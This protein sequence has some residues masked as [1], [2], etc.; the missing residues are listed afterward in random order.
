MSELIQLREECRQIARGNTLAIATLHI[1]KHGFDCIER[2]G[3]KNGQEYFH[4]WRK[5]TEG[6]K[7]GNPLIIKVSSKTGRITPVQ[8]LDE[9]CER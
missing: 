1:Q 9:I 5:A 7:L 4:F 6:H 8:Q 3:E 2:A